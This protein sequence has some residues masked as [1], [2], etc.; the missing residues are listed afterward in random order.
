VTLALLLVLREGVAILA[1]VVAMSALDML[2]G[3]MR[4]SMVERLWKVFLG[5]LYKSDL[6]T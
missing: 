5:K 6:K 1:S 3:L 4:E 2:G